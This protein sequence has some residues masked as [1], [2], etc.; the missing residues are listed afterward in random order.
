MERPAG[1]DPETRRAALVVANLTAFMTPFMG[2]SINIALPAIES[3]FHINAVTLSRVATAYLLSTAVFLVPMGRLADIRGRKRTFSWGDLHS[4]HRGGTAPSRFRLR[5]VFHA[6]H[7]RH[8][9]FRGQEILRPG[10]GRRRDHA[11]SGHDNQHGHCDRDPDALRGAG[12]PHGRYLPGIHQ[13]PPGGGLHPVFL[14]VLP[15]DFRFPGKGTCE[16]RNHGIEIRAL[17]F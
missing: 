6:Q 5:A 15:G 3:D 4:L 11:S 7:Q 8:H 13:K 9:E 10:L 12:L 2:S 14:S 17:A 16:G 1:A